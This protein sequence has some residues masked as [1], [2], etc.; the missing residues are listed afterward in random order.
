[1][2]S[3]DIFN[4]SGALSSSGDSLLGMSLWGIL[5]SLLFSIV[6]IFY[7]KRGKSENDVP[8]LI[9]GVLLLVFPYFVS[10][11]FAIVLIGAALTAVPY[12]IKR[13]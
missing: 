4:T 9:C 6:G 5:A 12:F 3:S 1:M 8:M 7:F 2:D 13:M 10:N 11:A